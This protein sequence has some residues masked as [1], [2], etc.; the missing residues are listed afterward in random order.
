MLL[1]SKNEIGQR[2]GEHSGEGSSRVGAGTQ[3]LEQGHLGGVFLRLDEEG[4]DQRADDAANGQC[5][6]QQ[7]AAPTVVGG[8]AQRESG[9]DRADIGLVQVSAHTGNVTDVIADV[10]RDGCR[11][12]RVIFRDTGFDFADEVSADVSGLGVDTAANTGK[13]CHEGSAHAVH[14]HDIGEDSGIG[15]LA[16]IAQT[17]EPERDVKNAE[18]DDREAH[19]RAGR[20]GNVQAVVQALMRGIGRACIGSGGDL[21]ADQAGKHRPDTAGQE[22]KRRHSGEHL[23]FGCEGDDQQDDKNDC[24]YFCNSRIL[25]LQIGVGTGADRRSDLDHLLVA[26]RALHNFALLQVGENQGERGSDE[27]DPEQVIHGYSHS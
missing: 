14:D 15:D 3:T 11:V 23:A 17:D 8:R 6:R 4:A 19:D 10:V 24:K 12:A 2:Q 25:L 1:R 27:A 22:R 5:D 13:Q 26:L 18:A 21:H 20:E 7:H 9:K 16:D